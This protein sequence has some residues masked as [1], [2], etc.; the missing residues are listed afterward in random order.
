MNKDGD[1]RL[2]L[3]LNGLDAPWEMLDARL[4]GRRPF[5]GGDAIPETDLTDDEYFWEPVPACWSVRRR[6]QEATAM[7]SGAGDWLLDRERPEPQPPPVT[8][9]AWRL[10]HLVLWLLM[11]YD[12]TF[13][14]HQLQIENI[15][16][17][18]TAREAVAML[19]SSHAQWR[20]ALAGV[21]PANLDTVGFSQMPYGLDPNERFDNLVA[22][23]NVEL[24][25]HAAEIGVLRDLYRARFR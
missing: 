25:H 19:R 24:A 13:G 6:G 8:T 22:W 9:I 12:Y 10:C 16:W 5:Q 17:P 20:T 23:T 21:S 14:S 3:L 15:A 2:R 11:R 1:Q 4:T 7:A 18:G